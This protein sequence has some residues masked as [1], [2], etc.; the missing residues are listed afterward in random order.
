M[1][2]CLR[3]VLRCRQAPASHRL[4]FSPFPADGCTLTADSFFNVV[5]YLRQMEFN[6]P[7]GIFKTRYLGTGICTA[8]GRMRKQDGTGR[9]YDAHASAWPVAARVAEVQPDGGLGDAKRRIRLL[10]NL[11]VQ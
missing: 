7:R 9:C 2:A 6:L 11:L 1:S 10:R 8:V 5:A 3:S 4:L